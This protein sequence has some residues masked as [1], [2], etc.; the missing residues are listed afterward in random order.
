MP[1]RFGLTN[2]ANQ[3]DRMK[4]LGEDGWECYQVLVI[5]SEEGIILREHHFKRKR[6]VLMLGFKRPKTRFTAEVKANLKKSI[7]QQGSWRRLGGGSVPR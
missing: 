1:F 5:P 7:F 6:N 3:N 4:A 2:Y